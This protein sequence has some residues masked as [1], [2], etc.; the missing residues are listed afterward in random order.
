MRK[1]CLFAASLLAFG[2]AAAAQTG[3]QIGAPSDSAAVSVLQPQA[4]QLVD[5]AE[6]PVK[7]ADGFAFTEGPIWV[8]RG[9]YLLFT[10]IPG[11]VIWK[12]V[13]GKR[14]S[15]YRLNAGYIGPEIFRVGGLNDNGFAKDDPRYVEYA[16]I[17]PDGLA[18]DRQGRVVMA[19]FAGRSIA[20]LERDGR[21]VELT[22]SFHGQRFNG[23]NDLVVKSDGA[24]YFTD[25]FGGLRK[26][27]NDPR[28]ALPINA[29]LRWKNGA[30]SEVVTDMAMV[31]GLAF[32]PGEKILYVNGNTDNYINAYDVHADG[33]LGKGRL[34]F[35]LDGDKAT[36]TTDGMKVDRRGD[37]WVTGPGGIWIISPGGVHLATI[38]FPEKPINFTFGG[39]DHRTLFVTAHTGIYSLRTRVSGL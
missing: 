16:M 18:L 36:G 5:P 3:V 10:D 6:N 19:T 31:N 13:P 17:G 25:T 24:I 37:V 20:R 2:T 9:G 23:P 21:R 33:S 14:A 27:A 38:H 30:I 15:V 39:A 12:L 35:T 22:G 4:T 1:A 26:R 7:L 28:K 34:F 11:N 32:S 8:R 29:V